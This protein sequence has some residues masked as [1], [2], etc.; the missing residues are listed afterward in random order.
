MGG[1]WGGEVECVCEVIFLAKML[2]A[3]QLFF[4]D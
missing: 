2:L 1:S 3:K 4:G